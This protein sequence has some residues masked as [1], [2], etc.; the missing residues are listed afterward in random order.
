MKERACYRD[1]FYSKRKTMPKKYHIKSQLMPPRF[2]PVPKYAMTE[3]EGCLGCLECAK[4]D[5]VYEVYKNRRFDPEQMIDS[6]DHLCKNCL[7]CIQGCKNQIIGKMKNPDFEA[8]GDAYW[9]PDQIAGLWE[10][11]TTG[12]IP[13]SGAGYRG[14]FSGPGFDSMWT[15]MSEIV[16]P[17][18][19]GIHGR[20]YINT[21]VDIGGRLS[22]LDFSGNELISS[23]PPLVELPVPFIFDLL[24][25]G[26]MNERVRDGFLRAAEMAGTLLVVP[27]E[28]IDWRMMPRLDSIIPLLSSADLRSEGSREIIG[29][30]RMIELEDDPAVLERAKVAKEINPAT[31][32]SIRLPMNRRASARIEELAR[33]GGEVVHIVGDWQG[34]ETGERSPRFVKDVLREIH[35]NLIDQALRD[36]ITIISTGGIAMAEHVA[37]AIICGADLVGIDLVL[38]VALECRVCKRC[39]KGL[40]CPVRIE[41]V[42]PEWAALRIRNVVCSWHSQLIE[43]LGAMGLREVR[44]LRGEVGRAMFFEDLEKEAFGDVRLATDAGRSR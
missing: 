30:S 8:L 15:D 23:A 34:N 18:R 41:S 14:P 32:V 27:E 11:S 29:R 33:S 40:S 22:R 4:R 5:C 6:I 43:V 42:D 28:D 7:R 36:E 16:R 38:E 17:T 44:R 20:E 3:R 31:V 2:V 19:D 39:V 1:R 9:K 21:S 13:V 12:K 37:K 10:Q 24:P 25:F 35:L 26:V